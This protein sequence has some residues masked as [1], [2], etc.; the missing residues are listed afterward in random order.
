M[1]KRLSL[2]GALKHS[3]EGRAWKRNSE[4]NFMFHL[5]DNQT[6]A[7]TIGGGLVRGRI[8]CMGDALDNILRG[9][10]YPDVVARLLGE[11]V[12]ISVL[13]ARALKFEGKLMVQA[14]GTN[15]G[16]VSLV[17]AECTTSGEVRGYARYD[18]ISLSGI[19][20]DNKN[21][22]AKALMGGGTFAMTIDQGAKTDLYQ[23]LSAI[24]GASLGDCAEHYFAQSEQIPTRLKLSVGELQSGSDNLQWRGSALMVQK[25]ADD[26]AREESGEA[27]DLSKAVMGTLSDEEFLD[28]DLPSETLL[29]RLFHE[30][31]VAL[32]EAQ[33]IEAKCTCSKERLLAAIKNFDKAAQEEML[34]NGIIKAKC[35]F[36]NTDYEFTPINFS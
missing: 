14:Q 10:D 8:V 25:I 28:P 21:P 29:Y 5:Q 34:E 12:M 26:E 15:E 36:C 17:A 20:K 31:G 1:R 18:E 4:S 11:A 33:N 30:Q 24:E 9:H 19:L 22:D 32:L 27:W 3:L 7:L 13:V 35:Q 23:G 2:N 6:A 16:A